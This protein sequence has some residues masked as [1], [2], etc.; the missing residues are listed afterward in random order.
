M[1]SFHKEPPIAMSPLLHELK[2][3]F[4]G[5][6]GKRLARVILF[7]SQARGDAGEDSDVDILVVLRGEVRPGE[8]IERGGNVTA[9]LSLKY[10]TLITTL[11]TSEAAFAAR[12]EP[13]FENIWREGVAL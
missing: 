1:E 8:E 5:L 12:R 2:R 7:G 11:Y 9:A 10:D 4:E 13:L 6:Y 3:G